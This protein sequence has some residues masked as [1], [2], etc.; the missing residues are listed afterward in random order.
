MRAAPAGEAEADLLA[1]V[2]HNGIARVSSRS[3][4]RRGQRVTFSVETARMHFFDP[5]TGAAIARTPR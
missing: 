4:V 2:T 5:G 1:G 3:A